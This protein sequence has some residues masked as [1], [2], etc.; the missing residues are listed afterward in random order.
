VA[1]R[2]LE[3]TLSIKVGKDGT[4]DEEDKKKLKETIVLSKRIND[5]IMLESM[6]EKL[7]FFK[8]KYLFNMQMFLPMWWM[9]VKETWHRNLLDSFM[10]RVQTAFCEKLQI[11]AEIVNFTDK[12]IPPLMLAV[13]SKGRKYIPSIQED[14]KKVGARV[15]EDIVHHAVWYSGKMAERELLK[16]M[17]LQTKHWNSL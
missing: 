7:S 8:N 15:I 2:E 16:R 14:E 10:D 4:L 13:M 3:G 12:E 5:L 17:L 11:S 1:T 9:R 6:M